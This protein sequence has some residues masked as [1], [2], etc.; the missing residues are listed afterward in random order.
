[1]CRHWRRIEQACGP[2]A[3]KD[4]RRGF[5]AHLTIGRVRENAWRHARQIGEALAAV[6]QPLL[7]AWTAGEVCLMRSQLSPHGATH[8]VL[9][10]GA[11]RAQ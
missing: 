8:T 3:Q 7:G 11:L 10:K 1:M 5:S 2:W 6:S 4:K 9:A